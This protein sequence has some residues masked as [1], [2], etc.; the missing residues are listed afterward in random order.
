M[1]QKKIFQSF[2]ERFDSASFPF[3][4]AYDV[5]RTESFLDDPFPVLM[6]EMFIPEEEAKPGSPE[7]DFNEYAPAFSYKLNDKYTVCIIWKAGLGAYEFILN[8]Y[9]QEG[10]IVDS[11]AVAGTYFDPADP[12]KHLDYQVCEF[13]APNKAA[14]IKGK[15]SA[16][17]EEFS[18]ADSQ[19]FILDISDIGEINYTLIN[20]DN[21]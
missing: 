6:V 21:A 18:P 9:D 8:I 17:E 11:D 16:I 15:L 12:N 10:T 7:D 1:E 19:R 14:I 5:Q 2:L 13:T 3:T 4:L 20:T